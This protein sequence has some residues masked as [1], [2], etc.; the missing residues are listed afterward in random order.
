MRPESFV[1]VVMDR[2]R[3]APG[4]TG[5]R[6]LAEAGDTKHPFGSAVTAGGRETRW[7]VT[8][9]LADGEKHDQPAAEVTGD[10]APYLRPSPAADGAVGECLT[11]P[12]A[13]TPMP[14][15]RSSLMSATSWADVPEGQ[16]LS[17]VAESFR[18]GPGFRS[19][20]VRSR[21]LASPHE[22][23]QRSY[24]LVTRHAGH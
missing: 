9:Q 4:V 21:L 22:I 1:P 2:A 11:A 13:C 17:G 12:P 19:P 8:G 14:G 7:Q 23:W 15:G 10:P 6:T 24:L 18:S 5:V 3:T 20:S 16:G